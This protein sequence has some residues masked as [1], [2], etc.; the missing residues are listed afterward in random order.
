M[1]KHISGET[2]NSQRSRNHGVRRPSLRTVTVTRPM[3]QPAE[4]GALYRLSK[5]RSIPTKC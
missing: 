3:G 5:Y 4:L 1:N 2:G